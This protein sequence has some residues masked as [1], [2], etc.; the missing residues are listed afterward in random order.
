M[1]DK[2]RQEDLVFMFSMHVC[3]M[4]K[5]QHSYWQTFQMSLHNLDG[6]HFSLWISQKPHSSHQQS[7]MGNKVQ[8]KT[9]TLKHT[10]KRL[11]QLL[12][13]WQL[14]STV[15]SNLTAESPAED[16]STESSQDW[17]TTWGSVHLH[18][19]SSSGFYTHLVKWLLW[20]SWYFL[21]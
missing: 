17:K 20:I 10:V 16:L 14:L 2:M 7:M 4:S 15:E 19:P 9:Q 5:I 11:R 8:R 18:W 6:N 12:W 1:S 21:F 3:K 13:P